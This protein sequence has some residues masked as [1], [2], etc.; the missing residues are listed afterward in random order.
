MF[1]RYKPFFRAGAMDMLAYKFNM[2]SWLIISSLQVLCVVFLWFGVYRSSA[3][4]MDSIINGFSFKDMIC[5]TVM[6]N[7]FNFVSFNGNTLWV[8]NE[9]IKNGTIAMSFVKPISYRKRFIATNLGEVSVQILLLGIPLYC[10]SYII[11]VSIGFIKMPSFL[12]F[13]LYILLFVIAQI[14]ATLLS[15]TFDYIFGVLCFY[16]TSSW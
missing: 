6:I 11:F 3:D 13:L 12:N 9:E 10:L 5:Y 8:I 16:T 14:I 15:N 4:G 1:K 2:F 7:I